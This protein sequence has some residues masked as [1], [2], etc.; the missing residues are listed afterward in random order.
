MSGLRDLHISLLDVAANVMVT[1]R[2]QRGRSDRS[3]QISVTIAFDGNNVLAI[4]IMRS[5][6]PI[7]EHRGGVVVWGSEATL[8][9]SVEHEG[10]RGS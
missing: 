6:A 1:T 2:R 3:S 7:K 5:P 4:T 8:S 10:L 9:E